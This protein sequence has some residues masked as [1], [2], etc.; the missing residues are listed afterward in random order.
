MFIVQLEADPKQIA[1][2]A[3]FGAFIGIMVL[4]SIIRSIK[5]GKGLKQVREEY[6]DKVIREFDYKY[7]QGFLTK[8][9][10]FLAEKNKRKVYVYAISD[11]SSV[12]SSRDKSVGWS[13]C[14]YDDANKPLKGDIT[15]GKTR[16]PQKIGIQHPLR[17]K[18]ADELA[19][20]LIGMN[21][22]IRRFS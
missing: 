4:F 11:I 1:I 6:S 13:F 2:L 9:E 19:D 8:D 12:R 7:Y 5:G 21:P 15:D 18:E 22:N 10:L 16:N 20:I 3:V 17:Q 14:L